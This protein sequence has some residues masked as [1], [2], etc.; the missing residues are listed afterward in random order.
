MVFKE[1]NIKYPRISIITP[2]FNGGGYLEQTIQ[3]VLNQNYPNLEYIIID[4]GS[5][6][7]SLKIIREYES[8]LAYWVSEEDN[9]LYHAIQKGFEKSTGEIMAWINSD[10]FYAKGAFSIVAELFSNFK[11]VNWLMGKPAAYDEKG[12]TT[13]I[14]D[15]KRWSKFNYYSGDYEWIQQESIFWRRTLWN[16]VNCEIN[17]SLKYAGDF[18]L[19]MRFFR[20]DKLFVLNS[21]LS[22]FRVRS[23]NQISLTYIEEYRGEVDKIISAEHNNFLSKKEILIAKKAKNYVQK[24]KKVHHL[25]RFYYNYKLKKLV[26]KYYDYPPVFYF[27]RLEQVFKLREY[28]K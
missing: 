4:G 19:W 1:D 28:D 8:K 13:F 26:K 10:D 18:D 25:I 24:A 22:G 6:D 2:N 23:N 7:D 11:Y 16:K 15:L 20:H 14:H 27:D 17:T 3:S 21:L 9:G 12:R 5:T